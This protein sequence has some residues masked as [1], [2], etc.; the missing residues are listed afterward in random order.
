MPLGI[1][2]T[3]MPTVFAA[4]YVRRAI[5]RSRYRFRTHSRPRPQQMG[6]ALGLSILS[7]VAASVTASS[8]RLECVQLCDP[9]LSRSVPGGAVAFMALASSSW[10]CW[11]FAAVHGT[12]G[13]GNTHEPVL[14]TP[15]RAARIR[16][17]LGLEQGL[18]VT[19][20]KLLMRSALGL[21]PTRSFHLVVGAGQ[22]MLIQAPVDTGACV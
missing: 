1:G 8:R 9:G 19:I 17:P 18:Q 16:W 21:T 13:L 7:G 2:M 11:L 6:G 22:R 20:Y 4:G 14:P 5:A 15:Q 3:M 12:R 10:P